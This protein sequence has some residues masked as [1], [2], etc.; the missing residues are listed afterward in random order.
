MWRQCT[1]ATSRTIPAAKGKAI[2]RNVK[3]GLVTMT[4]RLFVC[5]QLAYVSYNKASECPSAQALGWRSLLCT[6]CPASAK[7]FLMVPSPDQG[8]TM[9][10][11]RVNDMVSSAYRLA[12]SGWRPRCGTSSSWLASTV[13]DIA[14]VLVGVVHVAAALSMLLVLLSS[15]NALYGS[16]SR[17]SS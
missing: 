11:H 14:V 17:L 7:V 2:S 12:R 10:W 15:I 8:S 9:D 4:S 16:R 6:A 5:L 13:W 3:W 1:H